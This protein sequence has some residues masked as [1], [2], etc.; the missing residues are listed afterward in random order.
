MTDKIKR[1]A[2]TPSAGAFRGVT[3][4]GLAS[5]AVMY[6]LG[7]TGS[8]ELA[9]AAGAIV[10]GLLAWFGKFIR[11]KGYDAPLP[12]QTTGELF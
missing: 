2:S 11:E 7:K 1:N 6:V 5:I 4:G 10:S 8:P 3:K 12:V 9:A